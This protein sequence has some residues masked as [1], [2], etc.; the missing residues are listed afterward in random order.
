MNSFTNDSNINHFEICE[1]PT[2]KRNKEGGK[3]KKSKRQKVVRDA[4]ENIDDSNVQ[5][6]EPSGKA[7]ESPIYIPTT[8]IRTQ[9]D[10]S[11]VTRSDRK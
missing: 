7:P 2:K 3:E 11:F 6:E 5:T 10:Q 9:G 4:I 8:G 1:T